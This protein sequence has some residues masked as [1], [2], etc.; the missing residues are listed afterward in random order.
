MTFEERL[1]ELLDAPVS[2]KG[3]VSRIIKLTEKLNQIDRDTLEKY[4]LTI[5]NISTGAIKKK[6]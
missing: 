3:A 2:K 6:G 4:T 1:K 5:I